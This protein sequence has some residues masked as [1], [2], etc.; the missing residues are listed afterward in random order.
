MSEHVQSRLILGS[1]SPRRL[2]LLRQVGVEP[3]IVVGPDIDEAVVPRELPD[4]YCVRIAL[5]KNVALHAQFPH[6]FIITADTTVAVGRRILGKPENAADAA[7]MVRLMSGRAH[8]VYTAVVVRGPDGVIAKRLSESRVKVKALH[9]QEIADYIA[10]NDWDGF[11]G[12]YRIQGLF[13][14]FIIQVN[15]SPSG[16]IGLP[17]FETMQVLK[18]M[19]YDSAS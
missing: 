3:D 7:R 19:G 12:A 9:E 18:G 16:I 11:A 15:G 17:V 4:A 2:E 8:R 1:S 14:K 5:E 6:D 10:A 13:A